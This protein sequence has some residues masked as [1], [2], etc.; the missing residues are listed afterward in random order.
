M[1]ATLPPGWENL[2]LQ[3][4]DRL[5]GASRPAHATRRH[6]D[7]TMQWLARAQD[8]GGDDGVSRMFHIR[9]GWGASYPET[10]GYIIPTCIVYADFAGVPEF[11]ERALRMARWESSV[12]MDSGAVQGGMI[13][14]APSPAIFNTGQ[15]LFGWCAAYAAS[16]E[17]GFRDSAIRAADYLVAQLDPDGA[18]RKNLSAF[19]TAPIDTYAYNVRNA[20]ALLIAEDMAPGRGYRDAA[21][22]NVDFVLTLCSENGWI[23][24]NCLARPEQPLL[25]TIAYAYQGLLECAVRESRDD[26]L[27]VV[28]K[29]NRE[30]LE[31]LRSF[32][33]LHGRYEGE[34]Y[35]TVS[36][37]CL[38]GEAQTAIVWHR[39]AAVS[40]DSE[41]ADGAK[42]VTEQLKRTQTLDGPPGRTGGV[43]GSWPITAPYGRLEYLNWAAKFFADA[44]LLESGAAGAAM[45]G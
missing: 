22:R 30:L 40:G 6:L 33:T 5:T 31:N 26:V 44:L 42:T 15:V 38:T 21:M 32:G 8:E 23:A 13:S 9:K 29:G 11:R 39:L 24:K 7:A 27:A 4:W 25:H 36:W 18:W 19:T 28:E 2:P 43:K 34:W 1:G 37:R 20:W 12:Q 35:P 17:D 10:T 41:W 16:G 3:F 14:A 45:T